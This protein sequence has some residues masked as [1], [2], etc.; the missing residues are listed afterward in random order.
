MTKKQKSAKR[1][2]ISSVLVLCLC[3]TMFVGTTYAWYNDSV[4]SGR[5]TIVSGSLEMVLDVYRGAANDTV[6]A[7]NWTKI[8]DTVPVF[9]E[10]NGPIS[11]EPGAVQVAYVRVS[12]EGD[13][14]FKYSLAA[15]VFDENPGEN[16]EGRSFYLSNF[17]KFGTKVV[18]APFASREAAINAVKDTATKLQDATLSTGGNSL[19]KDAD[20]VIVAL[21]IYM[22]SDTSNEANPKPDHKPSISFGL[23]ALAAQYTVESDSF[24][25]TYDETAEYPAVYPGV[26]NVTV[27][28]NGAAS[29]ITAGG[30]T[31]ELPA[32]TSTTDDNEYRLNVSN[33]NTATDNTTGVT[34]VSFDAK[35]YLNDVEIT[36]GN[37]LYTMTVDIGPGATGVVVTHNGNA[38]TVGTGDQQYQY[39]ST[40]GII[41]I[42]TKSFSPF[43]VS[44]CGPVVTATNGTATETF[45]SLPLFAASVNGGNS[46]AGYTVTL[47]KNVDL[48]DVAWTPIGDTKAHAFKGVFDGNGKTISNLTIDIPSGTY[49]GLF[50]YVGGGNTTIKN[51]KLSNVY[52]NATKR[53][54]GL[55]AEVIGDATF[56]NC[57]VDSASTV[58]GSDANIAGLIGEIQPSAPSTIVCEKL[59]NYA[60]IIGTGGAA[61]VCRAAG[62]CCQ[63]TNSE[64]NGSNVTFKDCHNYGS[65]TV[66]DAYAG[67]ITCAAQGPY[68]TETYDG[69]SNSGTLTGAYTGALNAYLT[70][71]KHEI[72]IKNYSGNVK[73]ALGA[74]LHGNHNNVYYITHVIDENNDKLYEYKC[75]KNAPIV[76]FSDLYDSPTTISEG[77]MNEFRR[78]AEYFIENEDLHRADGVKGSNGSSTDEE[79]FYNAMFNGDA[80]GNLVSNNTGINYNGNPDYVWPSYA[81]AYNTTYTLA[82]FRPG[83]SEDTLYVI[84]RQ[85]FEVTAENPVNTPG[86][87][88]AIPG[89]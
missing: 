61:T 55:A 30:V 44:Y 15:K 10:T 53:I 3:F 12:N 36:S 37:T 24:S 82:D 56:Y 28:A 57:T 83:W 33:A 65:V 63:T 1:S 45:S 68:S 21:V 7:D 81:A 75:A 62:V 18:T 6:F 41:T 64:V 31:V 84:S 67:G 42:Y 39:N 50:G 35:L 58:I 5:N 60:T 43:A 2:F 16:Q 46:Y 77:L 74:I 88:P 11:F 40:T 49:Q 72:F 23:N 26:S 70:G 13:L 59:Y 71:N 80:C 17:L 85:S 52:I 19:D 73:Y 54:A 48:T 34:S 8:D 78:F 9:D 29:S 22:P 47:N 79:I 14:A 51:V 87:P 89:F 25:N 27:P 66:E 86:N 76:A 38:L 20:P 4:T 32:N 69:C